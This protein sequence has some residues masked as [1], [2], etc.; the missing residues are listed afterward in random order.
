MKP[1]TNSGWR[2]ARATFIRYAAAAAI[3]SGLV[4]C[5]SEWPTAPTGTEDRISLTT[6]D[7]PA[8]TILETGQTVTFTATVTHTLNTAASGLVAMV[9]QDQLSRN[10]KT[11]GV[12][13]SHV[14]IGQG[15]GT[16]TITDS[17]TIPASGISSIDVILPLFP[18]GATR[19]SVTDSV[20]YQVR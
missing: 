14:P 5:E 18:Q 11:F 13:Q 20:R 7:P 17:I 1:G 10:L 4:A 15:A 3:V 9:I 8:G 6:I 19:T 16:S 2:A 12:P